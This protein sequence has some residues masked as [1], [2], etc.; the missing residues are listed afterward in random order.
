[1]V[2]HGDR[3]L[4]ASDDGTIWAWDV[5]T[6]AVLR[7]VEAY[8]RGTGQL[9]CC[10]AVSGSKLVSGSYAVDDSPAEVRVWGLEELDLQQTVLRPPPAG[11]H[12]RALVSVDGEVWG[13]VGRDV[14]VWGRKACVAGLAGAAEGEVGGTSAAERGGG[15]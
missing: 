15:N 4:S 3:L 7:T 9:V 8:G 11:A 13:A 10:L 5:G 2:V 12:V 1:M 14:V 6:W